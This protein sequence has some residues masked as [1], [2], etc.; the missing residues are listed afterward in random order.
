M[1]SIV[2]RI[3]LYAERKGLS[4]RRIEM[5]IGAGNG[6][7]SKAIGKDKD[8]LSEWIARFVKSYADVNP[9]WLLTGNGSMLVTDEESLSDKTA[10]TL[11]QKILHLEQLLQV[12]K[13]K[14]KLLEDLIQ[15]LKRG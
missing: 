12:Q 2:N 8:V 9:T 3:G 4:I 6:T 10:A 7:L 5:E 15:L 11:T 14:N 13:E 1:A